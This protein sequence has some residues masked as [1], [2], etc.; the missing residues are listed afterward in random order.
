MKEFFKKLFIK[1]W[2]YHAKGFK[3]LIEFGSEQ[4]IF[5]LET[6]RMLLGVMNITN[7]RVRDI[8]IPRAEMNAISLNAS[9]H[10]AIEIIKDTK[11]SRYPILGEQSKDVVGILLA[12][13]LLCHKE[14]NHFNDL[15]RPPM[16]TPEGKRV[17]SLLHEFQIKRTHMSIV[18]NEYG[19]VSGLVTIEDIFE[20]IFGEIDDEHDA[21]DHEETAIIVKTPNCYHVSGATPVD[22]FNDFFSTRY[23]EDEFF[24]IAGLITQR[25]GRIP[26]T[27]EVFS[28]DQFK[29]KVLTADQRRLK[30]MEF[31]HI[32]T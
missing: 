30:K 20:E 12:K 19:E 26:K 11:H 27:N 6:K 29:V 1:Q 3:E 31:R 10:E 2:F 24:T 7:L 9:I 15:L 5:D 17:D 4:K 21:D 25:L 32:R 8:M 16:L 13:D 14:N 23:P 22:A 18:L 28:F